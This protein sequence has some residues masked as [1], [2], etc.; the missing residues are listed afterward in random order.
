M[1]VRRPG[2]LTVVLALAALA[3]ILIPGSREIA[4]MAGRAAVG[5]YLSL[6]PGWKPPADP[7][8]VK[9]VDRIA[10]LHADDAVI[11]RGAAESRGADHVGIY[12]RALELK[13]DDPGS[14]AGIIRVAMVSEWILKLTD[15]AGAGRPDPA[16]RELIRI[17]KEHSN[18]GIEHDP[19][20]AFFD[21]SRGCADAALGERDSA[22]DFLVAGSEKPRFEAYT[23]EARL[24]HFAA[25]RARGMTRLESQV[26]VLTNFNTPYY[27]AFGRLSRLAAEEARKAQAEGRRGDALRIDL[28]NFRAGRQRSESEANRFAIVEGYRTMLLAGPQIPDEEFEAAWRASGR[29]TAS[30]WAN[31][32]LK[33]QLP[34]F[35]EYMLSQGL[36]EHE[37]ERMCKELIAAQQN[38]GPA[39]DLILTLFERLDHVLGRAYAA[40]SLSGFLLGAGIAFA[41]L[42]FVLRLIARPFVLGGAAAVGWSAWTSAVLWILLLTPL[43]ALVVFFLRVEGAFFCFTPWVG[44]QARVDPSVAVGLAVFPLLLITAVMLGGA[45]LSAL[46]TRMAGLPAA[47]AATSAA[48]LAA[49]VLLEAWWLWDQPF[50]VGRPWRLFVGS[51]QIAL[52]LVLIFSLLRGSVVA[53][54]NPGSTAR[55]FIASLLASSRVA[56]VGAGVLFIV[57]L[58]VAMPAYLS[59]VRFMDRYVAGGAAALAGM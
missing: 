37:V 25:S 15:E 9:S 29:R 20:N 59:A 28:A 10:G 24:A 21:Y 14:H 33:L 3:A 54:R 35:E 40:V 46:R 50:Q 31:L 26:E 53:R 7:M 43:S 2:I 51:T 32:R 12:E 36:P 45:L 42:W 47:E 41:V 58:Y 44:E 23:R 18:W 8:W 6:F 1:R 11:L 17:V 19:D 5:S 49:L 52:A 13:P 34:L 55:H 4:I 38:V 22:I 39:D 48:V 16:S 56:A 27:G 30:E 57:S